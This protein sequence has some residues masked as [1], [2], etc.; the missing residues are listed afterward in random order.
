VSMYEKTGELGD[1]KFN[2]GYAKDVE[3]VSFS[4]I[5]KLLTKAESNCAQ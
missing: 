2:D 5:P 3:K 1:V 4:I